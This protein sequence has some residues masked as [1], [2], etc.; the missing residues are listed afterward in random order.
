MILI[1]IF[2][3]V[4]RFQQGRTVSKMDHIDYTSQVIFQVMEQLMNDRTATIA[5]PAVENRNQ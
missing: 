2:Q 5:V 4:P 3:W 1:E